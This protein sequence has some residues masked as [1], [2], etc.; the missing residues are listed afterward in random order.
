MDLRAKDMDLAGFKAQSAMFDEGVSPEAAIIMDAIYNPAG[1]RLASQKALSDFLEFAIEG[2]MAQDATTETLPGVEAVPAKDSQ[3]VLQN[4]RQ[5]ATDPD[6]Q[7]QTSLLDSSGKP[8]PSSR[9]GGQ[10]EQRA[11][12]DEG[13]ASDAGSSKPVASRQR[14]KQTAEQREALTRLHPEFDAYDIEVVAWKAEHFEALGLPDEVVAR[15]ADAQMRFIEETSEDAALALRKSLEDQAEKIK[16]RLINYVSDSGKVDFEA[17]RRKV[18][19][20]RAFGT[21]E[22]DLKIQVETMSLM[23]D[24]LSDQ[25]R[26]DEARRGAFSIPKFFKVVFTHP[27]LV[28]NDVI[29]ALDEPVFEWSVIENAKRDVVRFWKKR[30]SAPERTKNLSARKRLLIT[31]QAMRDLS[32]T[33]K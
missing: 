28:K 8:G 1:A 30:L 23:G 20:E 15:L 12:D 29:E 16:D 5:K 7:E 11:S 3:E 13:G 21:V 26:S 27:D 33:Q 10:E 18:D 6:Q 22:K 4:A 24:V 31:D 25:A 9:K 19:A 2:A 32:Q 14:F 17:L